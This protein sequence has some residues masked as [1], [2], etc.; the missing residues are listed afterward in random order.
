MKKLL[1]MVSIMFCLCILYWRISFNRNMSNLYD[2]ETRFHQAPFEAW[3]QLHQI[4]PEE[5]NRKEFA[6]YSLLLTK[7]Q[8][9]L[10]SLSLSDSLINSTI[11]YYKD[12]ND[13]SRLSQAYYYKGNIFRQKQC[14]IEATECYQKAEE[15]ATGKDIETKYLLNRIMGEIYHF[16]SMHE[17]EKE[18][19]KEAIHYA[20][21]L[22]D[23]LLTGES[24]IEMGKYY[25]T[26][27]NF[28]CSIN[29]LKLAIQILPDSN[30]EELASANAELSKSYLASHRA[31]SSLY[32]INRAVQKEKDSASLYDYYNLK[33]DAFL[34][35]AQN[36]SAEY[37]FRRSLESNSLRTKATTLY[38]L[39]LLNE[40]Y[41]N[42]D[43]EL[44]YLKAH[45]QY[46]DSLDL[47]RKEGFIDHLQNIQAY[48]RQKE[49][50]KLAELQLAYGKMIF[51]R[52]ITITFII[53]LILVF[54]FFKN[55]KR[56]RIL[57]MNI[58]IEEEKNIRLILW[59]KEAEN[60]LLREQEA[61]EKEEIQR[62]NLTIEYYKRLNAITVPI[63]FKSQNNQGAMHL[64]KEE[65]GII[66][67]NT[68]ACFD[69]F[70]FRLKKRFPQLTKE[71]VQLC[72]LIKME[73]PISLLS[74]IYHI[75]KTSISR[76]KVR[77]KEK[78]G[79]EEVTIDEF[80]RNF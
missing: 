64:K 16:K 5:L 3:K 50:A 40:Q 9:M 73:L 38:D 2:V 15:Y 60:K 12:A 35:L 47:K 1:F 44:K 55:Q 70:T 49:N 32:Y 6:L 21:L 29:S 67:E 77:L 48:K 58:A 10:D 19:K 43:E 7:G 42:K 23:S 71:E 80:I 61:R 57:E 76:K 17:D 26:T 34:K 28:E 53:I 78:M 4:N 24:H 18:A 31:D 46:R 72:C 74:E 51:Y 41:G 52:I 39:F 13:S 54:L 36:D 75:A 27:G 45:I 79:V 63:L 14:F 22:K 66:V 68:N 25:N 69:K 62:L 20:A 11:E 59:Q 65:W 56:K 33:A 30:D 37:Y 8:M